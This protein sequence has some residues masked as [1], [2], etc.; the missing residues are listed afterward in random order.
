[1]ERRGI[2]V[3]SNLC[4][5]C[6]ESEKSTSHLF[7]GCRVTWLVW[8]LCYDWLRVSSIDPLVPGSHFEQLK[9]LDASISVNLIVDNVWIALISEIL[10]YINNCSFK[11]GVVDHSEV[12]SLTQ[13]NV[14]SWISSKIQLVSLSFSDWCIEPLVCMHSI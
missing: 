4:C 8:N 7:F 10:R 3:E 6:R 9:I 2:G 12:F 5:L 14:W 11:G 1:M 13:V